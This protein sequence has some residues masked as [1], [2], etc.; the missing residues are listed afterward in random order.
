MQ[1]IKEKEKQLQNNQ[2]AIIFELDLVNEKYEEV[3]NNF[4]IDKAYSF[5]EN[6]AQL[7]DKLQN[8]R[9]EF[10]NLN[11]EIKEKEEHFLIEKDKF[12]D[13]IQNTEDFDPEKLQAMTQKYGNKIDQYKVDLL[14]Q[15]AL[16]YLKDKDEND[17]EKILSSNDLV[18]LLGD[19]HIQKMVQELKEYREN[20]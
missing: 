4:E 5:K 9:D 1:I 14:Y 19:K 2:N 15:T 7:K 3:L 13:E 11:K 17:T 6:I 20:I 8:N 16:N 10:L 12:N 18:E